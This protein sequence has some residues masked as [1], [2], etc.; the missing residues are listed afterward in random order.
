MLD[1]MYMARQTGGG[2]DKK[3]LLR[4]LAMSDQKAEMLE[5]LGGALVLSAC[6]GTPDRLLLPD[7]ASRAS[8][9]MGGSTTASWK[10]TEAQ[11]SELR[12]GLSLAAKPMK[13]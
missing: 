6:A 7:C 3:K 4:G 10:P 9:L 2:R 12:A 5:R 8:C 11:L 13:Q 1:P